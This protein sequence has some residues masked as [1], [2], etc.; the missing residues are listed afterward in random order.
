MDVYRKAADLPVM[1]DSE[2]FNGWQQLQ[3]SY[4]NGYPNKNDMQYLQPI[5]YSNQVATTGYHSS[6]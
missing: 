3:D 6:S 1:A 4:V 2:Q 5:P